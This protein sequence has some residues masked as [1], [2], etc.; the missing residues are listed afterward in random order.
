[1]VRCTNLH[2]MNDRKDYDEV[3]QRELRLL[4][5]EV[6]RDSELIREL[7]HPDFVE[8]GA[9]GRVWDNES[10]V[11]ALTTEV[12]PAELITFEFATTPI[13]PDAVL[14]TYKCEV[15]GRLTLRSSIW[16]KSEHGEWML[17]F[18]Q[19]TIINE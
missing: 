3:I 4:S 1:M 19:G 7:L 14:L 12:D 10:I 13:S 2:F 5:P 18:H 17:L 15:G 11:Q 9:S 16:S 6:R 8:F